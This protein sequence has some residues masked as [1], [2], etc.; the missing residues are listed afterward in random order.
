MYGGKCVSMYDATY[1]DISQSPGSFL[2]I[3]LI[4]PSMYNPLG[5]IL[6]SIREINILYSKTI[7]KRRKK[8]NT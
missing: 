5:H 2:N 6:L 3:S 1:F 7:G 4:S 8:L